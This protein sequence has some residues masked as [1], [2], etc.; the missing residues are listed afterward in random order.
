[1]VYK[2]YKQIYYISHKFNL[3]VFESVI[4]LANNSFIQ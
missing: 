1:M 4:V 3:K 2:T